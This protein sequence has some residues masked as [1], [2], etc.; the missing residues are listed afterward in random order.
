MK[1]FLLRCT[2]VP[3]K[4]LNPKE[5][6]VIDVVREAAAWARET[7]MSG[8]EAIADETKNTEPETLKARAFETD[9]GGAWT[10]EEKFNGKLLLNADHLKNNFGRSVRVRVALGQGEKLAF[11]AK[12]G[13]QNPKRPTVTFGRVFECY[14]FSNNA[15]RK[16]ERESCLMSRVV[17]SKHLTMARDWNSLS[18]SEKNGSAVIELVASQ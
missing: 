17:K 13:S 11:R 9:S 2:K 16:R 1:E 5:S 12:L 14:K 15:W 10:D 4:S 8:Q 18:R 3:L 7:L 6:G